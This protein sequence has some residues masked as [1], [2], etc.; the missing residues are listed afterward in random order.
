[1]V[2]ALH[3]PVWLGS[4]GDLVVQDTVYYWE[5]DRFTLSA[6][7]PLPVDHSVANGS[8]PDFDRLLFVPGGLG[9]QWFA[10]SPDGTNTAWDALTTAYRPV[11]SNTDLHV[12]PLSSL[13]GQDNNTYGQIIDSFDLN[14]SVANTDSIVG[15]SFSP[16]GSQLVVGTLSGPNNYAFDI[17]IYKLDGTLVR[18]LTTNGAGAN[19]VNWQPVWSSNN[20]IAFSSNSSGQYQVYTINPDGT[21]LTQVTTNGG[22][23]PSWSPDASKIAFSSNRGAEIHRFISSQRQRLHLKAIDGAGELSGMDRDERSSG[24][25]APWPIVSDPSSYFFPVKPSV[26]QTTPPPPP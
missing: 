10:V 13:N 24:A 11:S 6:N 9:G 5:W 20:R 19:V 21:N 4:T 25:N 1:M 2:V 17:S 22:A 26:A 3:T 16:D 18:Q 8:Q 7:P 15:V 12:A 23:W 14:C